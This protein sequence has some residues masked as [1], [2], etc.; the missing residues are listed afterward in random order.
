MGTSQL[1]VRKQSLWKHD[2]YQWFH[3][4]YLKNKGPFLLLISQQRL[5]PVIFLV[6]LTTVCGG[7]IKHVFEKWVKMPFFSDSLVT[8]SFFTQVKL[9]HISRQRYGAR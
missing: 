7:F 6:A 8:L 9:E 3:L 2:E 4:F 5:L 1:G